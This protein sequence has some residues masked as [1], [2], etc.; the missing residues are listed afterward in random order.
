MSDLS[1]AEIAK[2]C[3]EANKA[4]CEVAG[5][6]S[7]AEWPYC[8][9]WQR[10]SAISGVKFRMANMDTPAASQHAQWMYDKV[11][12]GWTY[13]EEKD[14][15]KKTHP[16]MLPYDE[17]PEIQKKKDVLFIAIVKALS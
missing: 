5:D 6:Y 1:V 9:Q 13:G 11:R 4:L 16:C 17:L 12:L 14:E 15:E 7:Q 2:V 3:H 8:A 10:D